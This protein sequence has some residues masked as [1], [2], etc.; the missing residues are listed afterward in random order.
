MAEKAIEIPLEVWQ[1]PQGDVILNV[2]ER[3]CIV[4]FGCWNEDSSPADYIGKITFNGCWSTNF[5][6]AEYIEFEHEHSHHSYIL[7]VIDSQW[8]KTL[9]MKHKRLYPN[10]NKEQI[11]YKHYVVRGHDVYAEVIALDFSLE[12]LNREQ[13]GEYARLIDEA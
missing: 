13:A 12:K 4:Y 3:E 8:L 2:S 11:G 9:V 6:H 10:S 5:T 7:S 1:D